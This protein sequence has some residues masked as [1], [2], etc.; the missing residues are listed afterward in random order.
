MSQDVCPNRPDG[1]EL[2]A[3]FVAV[4]VPAGVARRDRGVSSRAPRATFTPTPASIEQV[5]PERLVRRVSEGPRVESTRGGR[6]RPPGS[7]RTS[8]APR[9]NG[10][11][12]RE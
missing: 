10:R 11:R 6:Q 8:R 7:G 12:V 1:D 9:A 3:G 2:V 5:Q 4:S